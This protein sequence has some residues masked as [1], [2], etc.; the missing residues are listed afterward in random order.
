MELVLWII[1]HYLTSSSSSADD[2]PRVQLPKNAGIYMDIDLDADI[3]SQRDHYGQVTESLVNILQVYRMKKNNREFSMQSDN[4]V[5][6]VLFFERHYRKKMIIYFFRHEDLSPLYDPSGAF[7]P[8][9]TGPFSKP[10]SIDQIYNFYESL[11]I[12]EASLKRKKPDSDDL[13]E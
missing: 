6:P 4:D 3:A 13:E 2:I 9:S 10:K 5:N 11:P 1:R 12:P 8:K 7:R